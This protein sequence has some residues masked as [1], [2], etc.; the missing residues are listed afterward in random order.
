[1][2]D[3]ARSDHDLYR[4]LQVA[5]D[6]SREEIVRAYRRLAR[7]HH[8]DVRPA[9][10]GAASRFAQLS[11]AR[12]ILADPMRRA[13]Y[14]A[15]QRPRATAGAPTPTRPKRPAT[16]VPNPVSPQQP[17]LRP[18]QPLPPIWAG[19]VQVHPSHQPAPARQPL[20]R[21]PALAWLRYWLNPS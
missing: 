20:Q 21:S 15:N 10:P 5:R 8:P 19:P 16:A 7:A 6:A 12:A 14:D 2:F 18:G 13:V 11:I 1:M 17:L 9:D 4:V 3:E